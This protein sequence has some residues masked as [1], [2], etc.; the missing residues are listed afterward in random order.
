M[1]ECNLAFSDK[2]PGILYSPG[3]EIVLGLTCMACRLLEAM[4]KWVA[5]S[6]VGPAV[7]SAGYLDVWAQFGLPW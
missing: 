7:G 4:E 2:E 6:L 1:E 3:D 5:D